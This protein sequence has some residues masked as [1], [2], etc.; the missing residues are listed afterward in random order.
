MER[1]KIGLLGCSKISVKS[2][3]NAIKDITFVELY[4]C[5][6][7]DYNRAKEFS[8]K[9]NIPNTFR[10]YQDLLQCSEIDIV[11]IS[12]ANSLHYQWIIESMKY[13]KHILVEKPMCMTLQEALK[14]K[15]QYD[16]SQ[17]YLLEGVMVQHHDWQSTIKKKIQEKKY[18]NLKRIKTNM[19]FIPEGNFSGNYR[20]EPKM[21]GGCFFD[22]GSYWLQFIQ[23]ILGMDFKSYT[24]DSEFSGP[25]GC[26]WS[27]DASLSYESGVE[28]SFEASFEHPYQATHILEFETGRY[29]V[30]DF[31]R[32][33]LNKLKFN[34]IEEDYSTNIKSKISFPP[35]NFYT[36]QILFLCQLIDGK[37]DKN[38][39][40]ESIERVAIMEKIYKK[41]LEN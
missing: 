18:G 17:V 27:F 21:G 12:L 3:I 6:A 5:A 38:N 9:Y 7:R 8:A 20:E 10:D 4:G 39:L 31:F 24:A 32:C 13:N 23:C 33:T 1:K 36:N 26:D 16:Q 35:Q 40:N 11:Y 19:H 25:N 34:I 37:I 29:M 41:A 14:I 15:R 22:L 2:I 28:V 30:K